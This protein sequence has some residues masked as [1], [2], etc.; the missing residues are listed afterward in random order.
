VQLTDLVHDLGIGIDDP[1]EQ[2]QGD[3]ESELEGFLES[4]ERVMV[5]AWTVS[6]NVPARPCAARTPS[7]LQFAL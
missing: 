1:S 5:M 4:R 3:I 2:R 6:N 7:Y